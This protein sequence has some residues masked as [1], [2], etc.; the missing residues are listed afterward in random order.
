MQCSLL[1]GYSILGMNLF[2]C[3][4]CK[5]TEMPNGE[6][7]TECERKNFDSLLWA[8]L[9]VFQVCTVLLLRVGP[10][11]EVI[12]ELVRVAGRSPSCQC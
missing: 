3:K 5:D 2:G 6:K 8:L 7:Q 1:V 4:F 10:L 11:A 12:P 9:T